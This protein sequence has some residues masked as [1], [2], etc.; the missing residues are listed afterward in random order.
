M[1]KR[2]FFQK[3]WDLFLFLLGLLPIAIMLFLKCPYGYANHDESFFLTTPYR[4]WQGD[5]LFLN[6]WHLSQMAWWLLQLPVAVYMQIN[7]NADGIYLAFRYL[8]VALH[9]CVCIILFLQLRKTHRLGAVFAAWFHCIYVPFS[10]GT[11][12]YNSMGLDLLLLS[13]VTLA[14]GSRRYEALFSGILLALAVLCCPYLA[15]LFPIYGCAVLLE[16][17]FPSLRDDLPFLQPDRFGFFTLG[18]AIPATIFLISV[19]PAVPLS[20][21]PQVIAGLFS[22]PEHALPL[23]YKLTEYLYGFRNNKFLLLYAVLLLCGLLVRQKTFRAI[24]SGIILAFSGFVLLRSTSYINYL[25]FPLNMAGLY[26]YLVYRPA[27][28]KPL[29]YGVWIPGAVYSLCIHCSSNMRYYVISSAFAVSLAASVLL[30]LLVLEEQ[31][32]TFSLRILKYGLPAA[33]ILVFLLQGSLL[34]E[35]RWNFVFWEEGG[36]AEQTQLLTAGPEKGLWV[37]EKWERV[38][39]DDLDVAAHL[40]PDSALLVLGNRVYLYLMDGHTNSCFSGW[41]SNNSEVVPTVLTRL[42]LYYRLCPE[43]QPEQILIQAYPE[44]YAPAFLD[45]GAYEL[46]YTSPEGT[47]VLTRRDLL[48]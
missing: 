19:L 22:D 28:G 5:A 2:P 42:E 15:V 8:Y 14:C 39:L 13:A 30:I 3:H 45:S 32:P 44:E 4:L 9:I 29:F 34:L 11:L 33:A 23:K 43:K 7:G 48:S 6:E 36:P 17:L 47:L 21:W 20:A 38:Y 25:M 46:T 10:V 18:I 27:K 41:I 1:R 37:T 35:Q 40:E 31:A 26:F 12:C 16:K 24:L